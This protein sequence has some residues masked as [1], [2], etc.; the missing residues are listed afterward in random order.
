MKLTIDVSE[1]HNNDVITLKVADSCVHEQAFSVELTNIPDDLSHS[2]RS[3]REYSDRLDK[4]LSDVMGKLHLAESNVG[5]VQQPPYST[6]VTNKINSIKKCRD[7]TG[8]D[9]KAA[10]ELV[11]A[12]LDAG[13]TTRRE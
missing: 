11:E 10:K 4:Q 7:I 13:G 3:E 8:Y 2:L 9:L 1:H 12:I 6:L 5:N